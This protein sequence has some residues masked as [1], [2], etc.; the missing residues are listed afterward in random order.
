MLDIPTV[1]PQLCQVQRRI[2]A[3][4]ST[5]TIGKSERFAGVCSP[6]ECWVWQGFPCMCFVAIAFTLSGFA[7]YMCFGG[8]VWAGGAKE[9]LQRPV[10]TEGLRSGKQE[11]HG[12]AERGPCLTS[13]LGKVHLVRTEKILGFDNCIYHY[14]KG[15]TWVERK[16]N[17]CSF[18]AWEGILQ[19]GTSTAKVLF[20]FNRAR[21]NCSVLHEPLRVLG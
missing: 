3:R 2:G 18:L 1:V 10:L 14:W 4:A 8:H 7:I 11:G 21:I 13:G 19:P 17:S 5:G 6:S 15:L 9:L 12:V 16:S 20:V